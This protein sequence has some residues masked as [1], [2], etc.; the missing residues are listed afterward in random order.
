MRGGGGADPGFSQV[1]FGDGRRRSLTIVTG[2]RRFRC[3]RQA[4]CGAIE[5]EKNPEEFHFDSDGDGRQRSRV[6]SEDEALASDES[7]IAL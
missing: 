6:T 7:S 1:D 3:Q 5:S 4:E 2:D